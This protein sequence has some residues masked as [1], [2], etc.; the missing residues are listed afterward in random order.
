VYIREA[1]PCD[2]WEVRGWSKV[3]D[4]SDLEARKKNAQ[5][6]CQEKRV[7]LTAVVDGMKDETAFRWSG[8]PER[9]FVVSAGGKVV[10]TGD[11]GPWGF[12]PGGGYSGFQGKKRGAS[13]EEFLTGYL[14]QAKRPKKKKRSRK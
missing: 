4:A 14:K 6:F 5:K 8:W 13:M 10:Y 3:N 11:Q 1:H 12:N 9:L 2:G 7:R